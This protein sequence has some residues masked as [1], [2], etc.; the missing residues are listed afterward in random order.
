M[1]LMIDG[2]DGS[3]KT[4]CIREMQRLMAEQKKR[5]FCLLDWTEPHVPHFD[6][7]EF[8]DVYFTYE[9]TR[10]W[11]GAA[12]RNEL[13]HEGKPYS[14][15]ELAYAFA[16]DR[17][18]LYH[19]LIIPALQAGKIVIQDRGVST[20]LIYQ[21]T[22]DNAP[23]LQE[24]V[25]LP[26]NQLALEWAPNILAF[27]MTPAA[28][29]HERIQMRSDQTKYVFENFSFLERLVEQFQNPEIRNIFQERGT[30]IVEIDTSQTL[31]ETF[32]HVQHLLTRV[33][34]PL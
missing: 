28:V 8:Y 3:G 6:E 19:R 24:I 30:E 15:K 34:S 23:S 14:A 26:G 4:T 22:M 13:S 29:A 33:S 31:D 25:E 18:L 32:K 27:T 7:L 21:P 1:F 16:L 10:Q 20:S 5:I 9:P 2:I 12:I 17:Q 11:V